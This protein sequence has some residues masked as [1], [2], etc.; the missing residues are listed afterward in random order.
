MYTLNIW[1]NYCYS[2]N[3]NFG[4][5]G[6]S[7]NIS[8]VK[9]PKLSYGNSVSFSPVPRQCIVCM[10]LDSTC[11]ESYE[12]GRGC[13]NL[14]AVKQARTL[15]LLANAFLELDG[16]SQWQKALNAVSLANSEHSHPAGFLLKT[17]ILVQYDSSNER[18]SQGEVGKVGGRMEG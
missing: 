6:L 10:W 11:R 1:N 15:R 17:S 4:W 13:P 16:T 18:L 2:N 14:G 7:K 9:N 12:L 5:L 3:L 8:T